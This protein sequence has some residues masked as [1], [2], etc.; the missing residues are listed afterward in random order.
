ML[1]PASVTSIGKAPFN[2]NSK[3]TIYAD[4]GTY[5][6]DFA[7]QNG[8]SCKPVSEFEGGSTEDPVNKDALS[9]LLEEVNNI[10]NIYSVNSYRAFALARGN[11]ADVL[12][13]EKADQK[14]VDKAFA[15]LKTA[16]ENLK[17]K[18]GDVNHDGFITVLDSTEIQ[19]Y[20]AGIEIENFDTIAADIDRSNRVSIIDATLGQMIAAEIILI[21]DDGNAVL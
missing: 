15:A 1:I 21:D 9:A 2:D 5:G 11:A 13:D 12:K 20:L 4:Q 10:N 19:K 17:Y 18:A 3:I 6:Y 7:V 8:I 14:T 16:Y